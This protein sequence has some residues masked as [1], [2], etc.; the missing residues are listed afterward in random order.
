MVSFTKD[1]LKK[2][3]LASCKLRQFNDEVGFF[4]NVSHQDSV[5]RY[6]I[7]NSITTDDMKSKHS[8]DK[9]DH[10]T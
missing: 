1:R 6:S 7:R 2:G 8:T 9:S 5:T 4:Y 10:R 3:K